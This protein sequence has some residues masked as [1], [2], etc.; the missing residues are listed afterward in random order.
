MDPLDFKTNDELTQFF[1]CNKTVISGIEHP[2]TLFRQLRDHNLIPEDK[3]KKLMKMRCMQRKV[4]GVYE[5]LEWLETTCPENI[6]HFWK[7]VFKDH[8]LQ[9]YPILRLLRD[10][11]LSESSTSSG[12]LPEKKGTMEAEGGKGV[13]RKITG[14]GNKA[15]NLEDAESS[16]E[17]QTGLLSKAAP[18]RKEKLGTSRC[19]SPFKKSKT[20]EI[21]IQQNILPVVCGDKKGSLYREKLAKGEK[22]IKADERWFYPFEFEEYAGKKSSRNWKTSIRYQDTTLLKLIKKGDLTCGKFKQRCSP[23]IA[24]PE[25]KN[26]AEVSTSGSK[27]KRQRKEAGESPA[28]GAEAHDRGDGEEYVS[29]FAGNRLPVTCGSARG[30]LHKDRFVSGLQGKCIRM[31]DK[32]VTPVDFLKENPTSRNS[33]WMSRI[34]CSGKPLSD[35]LEKRVLNFHPLQCQCSLCT[36]QDQALREQDNDD[37]CFVCDVP[38]RLLCCDQCPRA[39]HFECHLPA[40]TGEAADYSNKWICTYCVLKN[41][42]GWRHPCEMTLQVALESP[43]SARLLDCQY[44]LL[45]LYKEDKEK[46]LKGDPQHLASNYTKVIKEPMWLDKIAEKLQNKSYST[47]GQFFSDV[48][49]MFR[50][51]A[52]LSQGNYYV[53]LATKLTSLFDEEFRKVFFIHR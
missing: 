40:V 4:K 47:V 30:I 38:G 17:E 45:C 21:R 42:Q 26:Q 12:K 6:S 13:K 1:R 39:F 20:E 15:G 22:C 53:E 5:V 35:L 44:L 43:I 34:L 28:G 25:L 7:C 19:S 29:H 2:D 8:I 10:K 50:N 52:S 46:V 11:L 18:M 31:E 48:Q 33:K 41:T 16:E 3:Y 14:D 51:C 32:W 37:D 24:R 23:S 49:L 9:Q 27:S 36:N